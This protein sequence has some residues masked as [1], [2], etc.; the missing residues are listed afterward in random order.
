MSYRS[1]GLVTLVTVGLLVGA[2][3]GREQT[4]VTEAAAG[5]GG[6]SAGGGVAYTAGAASSGSGGTPVGAAGASLGGASLGGAS[7]GGASL[8]GASLGGASGG[9]GGGGGLG[10]M[11][12]GG[13]NAAAG[14]SGNGAATVKMLQ[15]TVDA[16]CATARTCCAKQNEPTKLGDCEA[17]FPMNNAT[18]ASLASGAA[19]LD[20]TA[21]AGCLAAYKAAAVTC[22]ENPVLSACRGVVIGTRPQNAPCTNGSECARDAGFNTC[23]ITEQNG[24]VGVCKKIPHYKAGDACTFTCRKGDDCTFTTYGAADSMLGLCFEDDG[25]YCDYL[26]EPATCKPVKVVGATCSDDA[27][28]GFTGYCQ[29]TCRKRGTEGDPC[30]RCLDS[31]SCVNGKCAS[32]PFSSGNTCEGSSLGPY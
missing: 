21:L 4:A 28:C 8:G 19:T 1:Q 27:E 14:V 9:S 26:H 16:F 7:L 17:A 29:T 25:V 11:N 5:S 24:T 32:P 12:G 22:E 20:P 13:G 15:P 2:C 23:L 30:T 18:V 10:G 6:V 31:L 3:G